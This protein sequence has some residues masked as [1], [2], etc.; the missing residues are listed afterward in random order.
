[1]HRHYVWDI[2]TTTD[3]NAKLQ[4]IKDHERRRIVAYFLLQFETEVLPVLSSLRYMYAHNDAN[5]YNVLV[6]EQ[7]VCGLIDFGDMVYTALI[8]NVAVACTY[9]MLNHPNPLHAASL[10]VK[11]YHSV[12]PLTEQETDLLYYLIAARLC[13]SVTQSAYN[14]SLYSNNEHHFITEKPAWNLFFQLIR[15]NFLKAQN[16]FRA[17]CGFTSVIN[18]SDYSLLEKERKEHIGRNLSVSYKKHL[19][20]VKG[21]LQYLYDDKGNTF[22]DCV[23]NP[24][25]VVVFVLHLIFPAEY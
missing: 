8:N 18:E 16:E 25:H 11:G 13:I 12:Y 20:I 4:Y 21:A 22:V 19:K 23:N 14:A 3:A 17:A 7:K 2:S 9:A 5:D 24:S 10:V 6:R 15:I 1:M